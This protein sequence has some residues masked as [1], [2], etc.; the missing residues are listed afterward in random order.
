M[1]KK[2]ADFE[3]E[4]E[5]MD[6]IFDMLALALCHPRTLESRMYIDDLVSR[7]DFFVVPKNFEAETITNNSI[8]SNTLPRDKKMKSVNFFIDAP[9]ELYIL[10]CLWTVL[11]AKMDN[12]NKI[13][14]HYAYGNTINKSV[15]FKEDEINFETRILFNRYF[16]KYT[17]WRNDAFEMLESQYRLGRDSLL[18]SL[19]IKSYFYSVSFSFD[20]LSKYFDNHEL[21]K[22]IRVLTNYM[23][24]VYERY[25][26]TI[27]PFRH[28]L[29][30]MKNDHY[31][32]PIGLF[33]SMLLGNV[34]LKNFDK[35]IKKMSGVM[36]YGRYVDDIL[37]VIDKTIDK[38]EN[39]TSLLEEIFIKPGLFHKEG[40]NL[41]FNKF[42]R[43]YVQTNKIKLLY[44]DHTESKAIIDIYN[45]TIRIIPSQMN[46]L[47]D[48]SMNLSNFDE[49]AYS[50]ENFTKEKKIRDIGFV[51]VDAFKVGRFFS[52]LPRKYSQININSVKKEINLQ[53]EQIEKF[54]TGS[55]SIEFHNNWLNYMYFLVITER[56]TQLRSFVSS[57]KEQIKGLK[58]TTLDRSMYKR[59]TTVN[60]KA[61]DFLIM[62]L[63]TSL[64]LSLCLNFSLA[65]KY[66]GKYLN[67]VKKYE[68]AN[69]FEHS[70]VTF[71]L[72][73]YLNYNDKEVSYC[74][75][76]LNDLGEY[77]KEIEE[78]FKFIWS[79]RFI[80]YDELLLLL[81]YNYHNENKHGKKY[82]YEEDALVSKFSKINYLK[83][84][85]FRIDTKH[86]EQ[87]NIYSM[88]TIEIPRKD[89]VFPSKVDVAIGSINISFEK[90]IAACKDRWANITLPEKEL[91]FSI[92]QETYEYWVEK[93]S[94]N[95]VMFLVLPELCFPLYWINDL[96]KFSK[97]T[98]IGIITGLQYLGDDNKRRYNYLATILPFVSGPK[99]Y[100]NTFVYVRE[101]NDYSP[102]E[103][104]ELAKL[105]LRCQNRVVAEYQ[106]FDW[107][108]IRLAPFVC[109][110][111]T[112]IAA[113]ASLKGKCDFVT[114]SVFNPDTTYFS[115]IIDS[116]ARDLHAFIVQAN[117]SYYGDSR[118]TGPFDRDS[119]DVFKIKGGENDHTIIGTIDFLKFKDYQLNYYSD[120]EKRL[121]DID[122]QRTRKQ[123]HFPQKDRTK[124]NI[125]PFSARFRLK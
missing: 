15:L 71:P 100:R 118:M 108:G 62:H 29:E 119:K 97:M 83:Y 21:L 26:Y 10:D 27:R 93:K 46:P 90:C 9:I 34:Y 102:I 65:K 32:L 42:D 114:A 58:A 60:R 115:S 38:N 117:T 88:R 99:K 122:Y 44:I 63:D 4:P 98:Q 87:A 20:S 76:S 74:K 72:A 70:L 123:P 121:I 110:E 14:P 81:F 53:I 36:H 43:L 19:D 66:F 49:V 33:S 30:K 112:D 73:N 56:H 109:Y 57:V 111:L 113:R 64:Y 124:P 54:F 37:L 84:N 13:I 75:M 40:S 69:M 82:Q 7:I 11:L 94:G 52:V 103:F 77:P 2:I 91:F 80:H 39:T 41:K 8:I 105:G 68:H 61:K 28:D 95:R 116:A 12:D 89:L 50:V 35:T 92:L 78:S 107:K 120:I 31:P 104:E 3:S 6:K 86:E 96:I 22:E 24:K 55:Q 16:N 48:S 51:G 67:E 59:V 1:R 79:P 85:P 17:D 23:K 25:Y 18:V 125:K 47:P 45:D 101:K 106:I 5:Q